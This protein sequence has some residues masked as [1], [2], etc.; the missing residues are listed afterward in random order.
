MAKKAVTKKAKVEKKPKDEKKKYSYD[1]F[2][3][4][5]EA[6]SDQKTFD[7]MSSIYKSKFTFMFNRFCAIKFPVP[8]A[9]LSR[10]GIN[11]AEIV[12]YWQY[13]LTKQG[14]KST[15][16][17]LFSTLKNTK[18]KKTEQETKKTKGVFYPAEKT[19]SKYC[20]VYKIDSKVFSETMIKYPNEFLNELKT[21]EQMLKGTK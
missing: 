9:A 11:S 19:I 14:H 3:F 13:V 7:N 21:F 18:A 4:I 8:A 10:I 20:S 1:I 12:N 2:G 17:W 15:P 16:G 6:L 5:K